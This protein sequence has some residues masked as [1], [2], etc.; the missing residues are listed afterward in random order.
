MKCPK[1]KGRA[2]V[3]D[4]KGDVG[5]TVR[6]RVCTKCKHRFYTM[7]RPVPYLEGN[8]EMNRMHMLVRERRRNAD[9]S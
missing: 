3:C 6:L 2:R 7:E 9:Q 5:M 8:A 4:T 1:C